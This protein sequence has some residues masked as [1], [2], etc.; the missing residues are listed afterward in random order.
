MFI[1]II[2]EIQCEE[3]LFII[4]DNGSRNNDMINFSNKK[5]NL[6]KNWKIVRSN[7]NLG[8]GGGVKFGILNSDSEFVSWMPGNLKVNPRD[9]YNFLNNFKTL[10]KNQL[11]K[12]TRIGRPFTHK[13]KTIIFGVIV[14]IFFGVRMSDSGGTPNLV[15]RSLFNNP[16][17]FP[18]DFRFDVFIL[19]YCRLNKYKVIRP[20][21]IYTK[22]KYG[23]SHWQNG[24][25]NEFKLLFDVLKAKKEWKKSSLN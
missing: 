20:K 23:K 1:K 8:F 22:R 18:D 24:I 17:I 4:V 6:K 19:Y 7:K 5:N 14:S 25:I 21:I 3:N 16:N 2:E 15:H 9:V 11:V 13:I 12:A 10:N